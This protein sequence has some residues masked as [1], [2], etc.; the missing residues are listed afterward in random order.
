MLPKAPG[1]ECALPEA[2]FWLLLTGEVPSDDQV[3]EL[4]KELH[5]RSAVPQNVLATLASLPKETHPMTQLSVCML[6]LQKDSK[7]TAGYQGGMKKNEY[8]EAALEDA[9]DL[10]A[11]IPV[12]AVGPTWGSDLGLGTLGGPWGGPQRRS[13]VQARSL[14]VPGSKEESLGLRHIWRP[15]WGKLRRREIERCRRSDIPTWLWLT[16]SRNRFG[17]PDLEDF[18]AEEAQEC[19]GEIRPC[20]PSPTGP[21]LAQA[22]AEPMLQP[23][24]GHHIPRVGRRRANSPNSLLISPGYGRSRE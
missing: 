14:Q 18:R 11:K 10:V 22:P 3:R 21:S 5:A 2:A 23:E 4:T 24:I 15:S 12:V 13:E 16:E 1:G 6:A 8:W 20:A 9:L 7:F 17:N 19:H